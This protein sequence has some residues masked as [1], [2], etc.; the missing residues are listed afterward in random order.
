MFYVHAKH[1][2]TVSLFSS[3]LQEARVAATEKES[4]LVVPLLLS[5]KPP[6]IEGREKDDLADIEL[7]PNQV[8]LE[9]T[10]GMAY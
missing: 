5:N 1:F 9:F 6:V 3:D 10:T 8:Q 2:N 4:E 7:R